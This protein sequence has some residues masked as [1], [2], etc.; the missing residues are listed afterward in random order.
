LLVVVRYTIR[1][2]LAAS[3]AL[4]H[5]GFIYDIGALSPMGSFQVPAR[6]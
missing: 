3:S 4:V 5:P 6:F 2:F 1:G